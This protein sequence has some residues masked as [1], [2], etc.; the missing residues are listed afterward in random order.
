MAG[1]WAGG[2]VRAKGGARGQVGPV[3]GGGGGHGAAM[4]RMVER[5]WQKRGPR[6]S[7]WRLGERERR[8]WVVE[9][10]WRCGECGRRGRVCRAGGSGSAAVC[11]TGP[12]PSSRAGREV[13]AGPGGPRVVLPSTAG[14]REVPRRPWIRHVGVWW[15]QRLAAL[16]PGGPLGMDAVVGG[17]RCLVRGGVAPGG[18]WGMRVERSVAAI[19]YAGAVR[20]WGVVA[21]RGRF[22]GSGSGG[23]VV[24]GGGGGAAGGGG[25]GSGGVGVAGMALGPLL[26]IPVRLVGVGRRASC[27]APGAVLFG[28]Q[29][30][31]VG[32][33]A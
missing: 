7:W 19:P 13:S 18:R 16:G 1:A 29:G 22:V 17:I 3:G 32:G 11:G 4:A 12:H 26:G 6:G 10:R 14:G 27:A 25:V 33:R 28:G 20:A 31:R 5:K 23:G 2:R 21:R 8:E 9:A 24:G 30:G 15:R